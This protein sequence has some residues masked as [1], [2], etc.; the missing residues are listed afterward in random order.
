MDRPYC[1]YSCVDGHVGCFQLWLSSIV[2]AVD[3]HIQAL[4]C[5]VLLVTLTHKNT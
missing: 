4:V 3:I 2:A 5:R 1:L